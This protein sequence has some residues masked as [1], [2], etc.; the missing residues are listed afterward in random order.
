[1]KK[2]ISIVVI[3][4]KSAVSKCQNVNIDFVVVW[5]F[6][7]CIFACEVWGIVGYAKPE[8]AIAST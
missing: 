1:M 6:S 8:N 3:D 7:H 4:I 2:V 5:T